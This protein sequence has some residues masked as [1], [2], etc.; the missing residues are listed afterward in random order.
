MGQDGQLTKIAPASS[1]PL[2][3][4]EQ[5]VKAEVLQ[6]LHIIDANIAFQSADNDAE[7]FQLMFPG[8]C[9]ELSAEEDKIEL[10]CPT[11]N[12]SGHPISK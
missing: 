5:V 8:D 9:P 12:S 7:R 1:N 6:A 11:W 4:R 3:H 10:C 2:N